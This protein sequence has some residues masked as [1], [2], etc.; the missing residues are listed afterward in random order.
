MDAT[1]EVFDRDRSVIPAFDDDA[2]LIGGEGMSPGG[3]MFSDAIEES[4]RL[5]F[6][7]PKIR[8]ERGEEPFDLASAADTPIVDVPATVALSF[9]VSVDRTDAAPLFSE[10]M[11]DFSAVVRLA[12]RDAD[13]VSISIDAERAFAVD[14]PSGVGDDGETGKFVHVGSPFEFVTWPSGQ[15]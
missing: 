13:G 1:F 2:I 4:A 6:F 7:D 5:P 3:D 8:V 10:L 15:M 11:E 12:L 14:K 9:D